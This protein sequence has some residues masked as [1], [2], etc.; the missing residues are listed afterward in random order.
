MI[1]KNL[2]SILINLRSYIVQVD[3][4]SKYDNYSMQDLCEHIRNA[5]DDVLD[6]MEEK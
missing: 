6:W 2:K 1:D 3:E 4:Q 5:I